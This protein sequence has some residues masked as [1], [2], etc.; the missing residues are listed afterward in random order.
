MNELFQADIFVC[1]SH[2]CSWLEPFQLNKCATQ[3]DVYITQ[4]F[5]SMYMSIKRDTDQRRYSSEYL[6]YNPTK[7]NTRKKYKTVT[8]GNRKKCQRDA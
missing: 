7:K 4:V 3:V 2:T 6:D 5:V 1:N 8:D